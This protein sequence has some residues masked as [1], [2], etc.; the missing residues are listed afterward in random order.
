MIA[1]PGLVEGDAIR[2]APNLG[3]QQVALPRPEDLGG[4]RDLPLDVA[5]E[6]TLAA[7]GE[8]HA[9]GLRSFLYV[10][11]EIGIGGGIVLDGE[12]FGGSHGWAGE[13]GHV[14]IDPQGRRLP[15]RFARLPGAVRGRGGHPRARPACP[16]AALLADLVDG[17]REGSATGAGRARSTPARRSASRCPGR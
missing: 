10:S 13:I 8:R 3:W 17:A 1:V 5:N 7:L 9:T 16:P 6:A 4:L 14:T 11:G 12:L 2:I 15:L